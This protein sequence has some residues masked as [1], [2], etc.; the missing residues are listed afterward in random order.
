MDFTE[1]SRAGDPPL[2]MVD[3]GACVHVCPPDFMTEVPL[4]R[5]RRPVLAQVASGERLKFYGVRKVELTTWRGI[6]PI[7]DFS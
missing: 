6:R 7:I 3:S 1:V 2:L 4:R 5:V